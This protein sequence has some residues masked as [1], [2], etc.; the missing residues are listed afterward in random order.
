MIVKELLVDFL[1]GF[2]VKYCDC[3]SDIN[4]DGDLD[5]VYSFLESE[6]DVEDV[7]DEYIKKVGLDKIKSDEDI[8]RDFLIFYK[9]E[10]RN[11]YDDEIFSLT[12][13]EEDW[14]RLYGEL[15]E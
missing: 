3:T 5:F 15:N 14:I 6:V 9:N 4:L 8:I 10:N 12:D 11:E 1:N 2:I 7:V 13:V